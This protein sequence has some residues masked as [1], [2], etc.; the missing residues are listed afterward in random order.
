[1]AVH[2][3][4]MIRSFLL[5]LLASWATFLG[6]SAQ[7]MVLNPGFD[8]RSTCPVAAGEVTG[9]CNNWENAC[10]AGLGADYYAAGCPFPLSP[11]EA[12]RSGDAYVGLMAFEPTTGGREYVRG[13]LCDALQAGVTYYVEYYVSLDEFS[14]RAITQMG[15]LLTSDP[16]AITT[17]PTAP[18][19]APQI[20]STAMLT[21]KGGWTRVS[22]TFVATG[23]EQYIYI[24]NF[25]DN[26]GTS[27]LVLSTGSLAMAYY[28]VEDVLVVPASLHNFLGGDSVVC[29]SLP[30]WYD[31]SN[32]LISGWLWGDGSTNDSLFV[33]SSGT[34]TLTVNYGACLLS[35]TANVSFNPIPDLPLLDVH[36]TTGCVGDVISISA[37]TPGA[38]AY[39]W[40]PPGS[41][42]GVSCGGVNPTDSI[43]CFTTPGIYIVEV[44]FG[45]CS[46]FDTLTVNF[47]A[48]PAL[49]LGPD[50]FFCPGESD[51]LDATVVGG[52]VYLW[53]TGDTVASIVVA[54]SGTY[55][56]RVETPGGCVIWDTVR[57][58]TGDYPAVDLGPDLLLC[59]GDSVTLA[60]GGGYAVYVWSTG[61]AG[62]NDSLLTV[63]SVG[64]YSVTV[65]DLIGCTTSDTMEVL[66]GTAPFAYLGPDRSIC[67]DQ[68]ILSTEITD[69]LTFFAWNTGATTPEITVTETGTYYVDAANNCGATSD[70]VFVII[71]PDP[72]G[73][74]LPNVFTPNDDGINDE[75]SALSGIPLTDFELNLFDRWGVL[76]Y[77]T[78][79]PFFKWDGKSRI[80]GSAVPEGVYFV[81]FRAHDCAGERVIRE[82]NVTL[83]R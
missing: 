77:T 3:G 1:M 20:E 75:L 25:R 65:S 33:N 73:Y 40:S 78:T 19:I 70:T 30:F 31:I 24:G 57:V 41:A 14:N 4:M 26:A 17:C 51:T 49:D 55:S 5:S 42:S 50:L 60:A 79:D 35:D 83:L 71:I 6:L 46:F 76:H 58:T 29:D 22:G 54:D 36:D 67:G 13:E 44:V 38:S 15:A 72:D 28:F 82:G 23:G 27:D 62:V 81:T 7:N 9:V 68:E 43:Q 12:S 37:F 21:N 47:D 8:L 10:V 48:R 64:V 45:S 39:F 2:K 59:N 74:L 69:T 16:A 63:S 18:G 56:V 34:Y 61:L 80:T 11:S 53:N 52:G 66:T 32:P